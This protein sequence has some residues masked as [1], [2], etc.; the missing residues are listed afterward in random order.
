[1]MNLP[2][3]GTLVRFAEG[4]NENAEKNLV[5]YVTSVDRLT[6]TMRVCT[7]PGTYWSVDRALAEE[8]N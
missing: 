5:G 8:V 6:G 2:V 4:T 1:M 3:A 7:K